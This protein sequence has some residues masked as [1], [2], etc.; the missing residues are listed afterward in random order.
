LCKLYA[1]D[2]TSLPVL[3]V[4]LSASTGVFNIEGGCYA[5]AIKLR[6]ESEPDIYDAIRFGTVL[7]N[8]QF[9][10][11]TRDVDYDDGCAS[12]CSHLMC[13]ACVVLCDQCDCCKGSPHAFQGFR[14]GA[15]DRAV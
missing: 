10:P 15:A 2:V 7:E 4:C 6:H 3:L 14:H 13:V 1:I 11:V 8:V 5:K 9:D 12:S